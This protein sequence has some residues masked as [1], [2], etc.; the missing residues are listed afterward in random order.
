MHSASIKSWEL[1]FYWGVMGKNALS[2]ICH[3]LSWLPYFQVCS[4]PGREHCIATQGRPPLLQH[5]E[6]CRCEKKRKRERVK[7]TQMQVDDRSTNAFLR[8]IMGFKRYG[9]DYTFNK[10]QITSALY[11]FKISENIFQWLDALIDN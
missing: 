10:I 4:G 1:K 11:F 6:P 5:R 8:M 9:T 3:L 7:L 2:A